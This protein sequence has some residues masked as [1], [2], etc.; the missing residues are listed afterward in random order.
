M[1]LT[2]EQRE[3]R[4][5]YLGS[6]DAGAVCGEHPDRTP[7][8]VWSEKVGLDP[9][10]QKQGRNT[11]AIAGQKFEPGVLDHFEDMTGEKLVRNVMYVHGT[12]PLCA[13]LDGL[14]PG[15]IVEAKTSALY[16]GGQA[17]TWGA[18]G[19]DQVPEYVKIQVAHQ[20][21]VLRDPN[22]LLVGGTLGPP[23]PIEVAE[24]VVAAF[25]GGGPGFRTYRLLPDDDLIAAV[26]ER[27]VDFWNRYVV[28][29]TPP[30]FAL[31]SVEVAKRLRRVAQ[32]S[33]RLESALL[34]A[35]V[36]ARVAR[37]AAND[38]YDAAL[39]AVL[40]ALVDAEEGVCDDGRVLTYFEYEKPAMRPD[41]A[42]PPVKYRAPYIKRRKE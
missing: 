24:C 8:D 9:G 34:D 25:I 32:K 21:A 40:G 33:A 27:E 10:P 19:T 22:K 38:G 37:K 3:L 5:R 20:F 2:A 14:A 28:T 7:W 36:A 23:R 16:Y 12:L 18:E 1:A 30:P 13:N 39:S 15:K 42:L 29:D 11:P 4:K 6:S 17:A 31:P 41:P 35:F 26:V